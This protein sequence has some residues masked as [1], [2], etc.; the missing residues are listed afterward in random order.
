MNNDLIKAGISRRSFLTGAGALGVLAGLGLTGCGGSNSASGSAAGSATAA[1][2]TYRDELQVALP[3]SPDGLDPHTTSSLATVDIICNVVEPLFG[4]DKNYDPKPVLA[5]DYK[6]SDD[7][8]TYTIELREGVKFHNGNELTPD[9]VVA[10]MNRWLTVNDRAASLL[11]GATFA[12]SGDHAVTCTLT[13]PA[14]DFLT[15]LGAHSQY[16]GIFPADAISA[17]GDTGITDYIGTGAYKF[18][19]W[20]QD[21]YIH[22]TRNDGYAPGEGKAS[23]YV[24]KVSAPTKDIYYQFATDASTRVSAFETGEYDIADEIPTEN[25]HDFDGNDDVKLISH[26]AG[27]LTAFLNMNT[28]VFADEEIRKCALMAIDCKAAALAA[29]GEE[30]LFNIDPNL[31]NPENSAWATDAGKKYFNQADPKAAKKALAKT[32]YNGE[33]VKLLT[34]PDYKEMYNA[35]VALQEQL[36]KAGFTAE[37]ES[38]EFAT[39]M[40][41]RSGK[42]DQW[43]L[44][45]A[46]TSYKPIPAQSL[47]VSKGF[48][49]LSDEK[50]LALVAETRTADDQKAAAKKWAECQERLYEIAVIEPLCHYVSITGIQADV[51][52]FELLDGAIIWNAKR[53]Q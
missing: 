18:V 10:S 43:D 31:G 49:G 23:G 53:P 28:G 21:Q 44:F 52:G 4:M 14:T 7:G 15:I 42:P 27:V 1:D 45:V 51:E 5:K 40:D 19:E 25:Y 3:A 16:P 41:I 11:P 20:K 38:Y 30:E 9:D 29:Y 48:Y 13:E 37:V 50:A 47:S 8:L 36:E 22:L 33:T 6:V 26:N 12:A 35:T 24:G 34:T 17:A 39:F 2:V 46:S 32:S